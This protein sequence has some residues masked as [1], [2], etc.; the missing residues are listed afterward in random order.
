MTTASAELLAC[1][2]C[3][4]PPARY[5]RSYVSEYEVHC[6]GCGLGIERDTAAD[7]DAAWNRRAALTRAVQPAADG[8]AVE[9]KV[10]SERCDACD[11]GVLSDWT[12]CPYC[13]AQSR[14]SAA[15]AAHPA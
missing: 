5:S 8:G 9:W 15:L 3:G 11:N 4:S 10:G 1:P 2:C 12:Y 6:D 7:A 13:G 14:T